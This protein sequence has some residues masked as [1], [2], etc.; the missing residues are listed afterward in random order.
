M[1]GQSPFKRGTEQYASLRPQDLPSNIQR[2]EKSRVSL[3]LEE[4]F[5]NEETKN[6][7]NAMMI[8]MAET[9]KSDP[10]LEPVEER[11]EDLEEQDSGIVLT[12]ASLPSASNKNQTN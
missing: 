8:M 7:I 12:E 5:E 11:L 2:K 3:I 4:T 1:G 10:P 9:A 6:E